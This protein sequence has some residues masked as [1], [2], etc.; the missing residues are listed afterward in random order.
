M[1]GV[2][3]RQLLSASEL[4]VLQWACPPDLVPTEG[5][6]HCD[7][8]ATSQQWRLSHSVTGECVLLQGG[9]TFMLAYDSEGFSYLRDEIAP[10]GED[11]DV[12]AH[13]HWRDC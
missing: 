6:V 11:Q 8:C 2:V 7:W 12:D 3:I 13:L 9:G 10:G 1:P 5:L 4:R